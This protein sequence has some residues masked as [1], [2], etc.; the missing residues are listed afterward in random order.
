[1]AC[2]D[3][4][5]IEDNPSDAELFSGLIQ[6]ASGGKMRVFAANRL[7][8]ACKM[9]DTRQFTAVLVDLN[10][11]EVSGEQP[12]A[13]LKRHYPDMA[14]IAFTGQDDD[15]LAD[16]TARL[17][18]QDFIV[19]GAGDGHS[20]Q[21]RIQH[22]I[23]RQR[24]ENGLFFAANYDPATGLPKYQL[25]L[26]HLRHY[27]NRA[28]R[29]E[30]DFSLILIDLDEFYAFG[31]QY[32]FAV[33]EQVM[34]EFSHRVKSTIRSS[35]I[36]ARYGADEIILLIGNLEH[37]QRECLHIAGKIQR[38]LELPFAVGDQQW[39]TFSACIGIA[40]I[41]PSHTEEQSVLSMVRFALAAAKKRGEG[42]IEVYMPPASQ[43]EAVC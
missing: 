11:Q 29:C 32:G 28:Q 4:L 24:H 22:S 21:R 18:A 9:L 36:I 17:G 40:A 15:L 38:L 31:E 25:F 10:L 34:A 1:M 6:Q 5:Y 3:V 20:L 43:P 30:E 8:E 27:L 16:K 42:S 12:I 19:K 2:A 23:L 14:V 7:N 13:L 33:C 37:E 41:D 26:E 35:D 39:K